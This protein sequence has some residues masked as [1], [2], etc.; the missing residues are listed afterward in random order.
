MSRT[1]GD[2]A[3]R[4]P[5]LVWTRAGLEADG[6]EGFVLF[7]E[8][9]AAGVPAEP[10]IYMVLRPSTEP[11]TF[12]ERTVAGDHRGRDQSVPVSLLEAKWVPATEIVYVGKA[13][14]REKGVTP[15]AQGPAR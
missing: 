15:S 4:E 6:Y 14:A 13:N 8:L 7:S 2:D 1:F 5:E 12:L 10:G 3:E 9:R 11:P